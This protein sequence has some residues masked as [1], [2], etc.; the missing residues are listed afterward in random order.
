MSI[1]IDEYKG[2]GCY[3]TMDSVYM[4]DIMAQAGREVWGSHIVGT[5]Q[6]NRCGAEM[7]QTF[8]K[9]KIRSYKSVCWQNSNK[10]LVIAAWGDNCWRILALPHLSLF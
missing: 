2:N 7:V 4:G 9:M 3:V 10:S 1:M 8:N 6:T 5:V